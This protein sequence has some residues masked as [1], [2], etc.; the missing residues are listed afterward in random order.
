[1]TTSTEENYLKAIY[2]L[3]TGNQNSVLTSAIAGSLSTSSASVTDMIKKLSEKNM[4]EYERYHGV[5][6]TRKGEK[7]ALSIIRRHRLWEVFLMDKLKFKWD[8][9]HDLAEELEHVSSDEL[10][11]RLDAFL[12]FP[13]F[14]PH[15]DPIPDTNGKV[16]S[17]G[18]VLL[19]EITKKGKY[20]LSGV[21][22]HSPS[23]LQYLEKKG[24]IPGSTFSIVEMDEFDNS[25]QI[26]FSNKKSIFISKEVSKNLLV[27]SH[28]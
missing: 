3:S 24:L 2:H 17:N 18:Q 14:D 10:T 6:I 21:N 25:M 1:M 16:H 4:V 9:V 27:R 23:F 12:G 13:K 7:V 8:E 15:G 5:R 11:K 19:S 22:D 20:I 28:E 26:I